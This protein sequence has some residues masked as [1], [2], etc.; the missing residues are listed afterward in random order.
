MQ[1]SNKTY[2]RIWEF[3]IKPEMRND[4]ERIYGSEGDWAQLFWKSDEFLFTELY[5][6]PEN[7]NRYVTIDGFRSKKGFE[8]IL[9]EFKEE[10]DVLDRRCEVLTISERHIGDFVS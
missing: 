1:P 8:K 5:R 4:F 2:I 7:E 3:L 9:G 6:D 10:Y